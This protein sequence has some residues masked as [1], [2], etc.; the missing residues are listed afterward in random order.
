MKKLIIAALAAALT[1]SLSYTAF[2]ATVDQDTHPQ[3]VP[4]TVS[5]EIAPECIVR[6]PVKT[7]IEFNATS[8]PFGYIGLKTAR[9]HPGKAI[10]ISVE[11]GAL[12]NDHDN[13]KTLPYTVMSGNSQFTSATYTTA[14][15]KT[16]LTIDIKQ[17]DWDKA[18][19]GGYEGTVTFTMEYVDKK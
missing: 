17:D 3:E 6:I 9:I 14:G 11:A 2:A 10:K 13:T 5:A 8:T 16:D 19:A 18:F 4:V 12:T 7:K 1:L 15:D